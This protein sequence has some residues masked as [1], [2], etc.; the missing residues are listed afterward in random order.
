MANQVSRSASPECLQRRPPFRTSGDKADVYTA[1]K[2]TAEKLDQLGAPLAQ[3][4]I[5]ISFL[6]PP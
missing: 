6:L 4:L 5:V 2:E 1:I 3:V